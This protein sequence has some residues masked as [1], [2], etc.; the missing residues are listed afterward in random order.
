[1][2]HEEVLAPAV[3][4]QLL[5]APPALVRVGLHGHRGEDLQRAL[6]LDL[7]VLVAVLDVAADLLGVRLQHRP[8]AHDEE[9]RVGVDLHR[10]VRLAVAA[11]LHERVP[12]VNEG[13]RIHPGV[14]GLPGHPEVPEAALDAGDGDGL[15]AAEGA[16]AQVQLVAVAKDGVLV[17]GEHAG[18]PGELGPHEPGLVARLHHDAPAEERGPGSRAHAQRLAAPGVVVLIEGV[19]ARGAVVL[20]RGPAGDL[21]EAL[22]AALLAAA[23]GAAVLLVGLGAVRGPGAGVA[24][25]AGGRPLL[26]RLWRLRALVLLLRPVLGLFPPPRPRSLAP[27]RLVLRPLGRRLLG[28]ASP[29]LVLRRLLRPPA[30]RLRGLGPLLVIR[31]PLERRRWARV[32]E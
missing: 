31:R 18:P 7:L 22:H 21:A 26:G 11:V 5:L 15:H 28:L 8:Q 32:L 2:R 29:W 30:R 17:A 1:M 3:P 14:R 16:L 9:H 10:P 12:G 4:V 19:A 20:A 13:L 23:G 25:P 27:L 24:L 6:E